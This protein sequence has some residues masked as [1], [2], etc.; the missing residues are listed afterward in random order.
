[1]NVGEGGG[2]NLN[3][4][5]IGVVEQAFAQA[6]AF[7]SPKPAI[8]SAIEILRQMTLHQQTSSL[9]QSS[10]KCQAPWPSVKIALSS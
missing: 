3:D 6:C 2:R 5:G 7:I 4:E 8:L 9:L 1:M 10:S